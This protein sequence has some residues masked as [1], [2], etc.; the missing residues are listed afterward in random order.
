MRYNCM[1]DDPILIS[2]ITK[3][4]FRDAVRKPFPYS[5]T[6]LEDIILTIKIVNIVHA[7]K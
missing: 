3:N 6:V 7:L 2:I 5:L 1:V 4:A